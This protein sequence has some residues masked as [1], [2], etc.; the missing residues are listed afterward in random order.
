MA[1]LDYPAET[2][3]SKKC[4]ILIESRIALWDTL[5]SCARNGSLDSSIINNSIIPN[6]FKQ[7]FEKH[8]FIRAIFFNGRKAQEVYNRQVL[9]TL[10]EKFQKLKQISLPSTSP[11]MAMLNRE[12]KRD[13][14]SVILRELQTVSLLDN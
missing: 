13:K 4:E 10:P 14:W 11:A 9:P 6:N 8:P 12:Q 3:Y 5:E 1:L 7:F 2:S